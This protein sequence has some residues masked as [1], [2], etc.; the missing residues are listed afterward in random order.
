M[1]RIRPSFVVAIAAALASAGIAGA[2]GTA[3]KRSTSSKAV[4]LNL[5][6]YSTPRPVLTRIISDFQ[7]TSEGS[8]ISF[9]ASYGASS[10]QAAAV[11]AGL[12]ADVLLLNTGN[13]ILRLVDKGIVDANWD[14][15]SSKGVA[16]NSV[17]VFA[18]RDG[19][20]KQI[21]GWNDLLKPG[22]E[23]V[24]PNPFTAGIAKWNILAAYSAQRAVGK[25][26]KQA[27]DYVETLFDHVVAQDSSGSN[28]T[29]T[30]LSGKGDVL[31]TFESE[32]LNARA[33]GRD[34]QY[35]IPRQTMLI[36]VYGAVTKGS[37]HKAEVNAFLRYLK[38]EPVQRVLA[39]NGYRPVNR[40]VLKEFSTQFPVRPGEIPIDSKVLGGWRAVE[41]KWFDPKGGIMAKIEKA[42]GVSTAAT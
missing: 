34:I 2:A 8:G 40:K 15:Q 23:V 9:N 20:P 36:D 21:R 24:T 3:T 41:K 35:V 11:E 4:T 31:L 14:K 22:V 7:K 29:N 19:N 1:Q 33:A 13:D 16:W 18:L 39:Q 26:D 42:L 6:A 38:S 10:A 5:V 17:V 30:F 25:T 28:A 27:R 32:A 12:P 37:E